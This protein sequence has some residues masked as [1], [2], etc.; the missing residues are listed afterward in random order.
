MRIYT[1]YY[2]KMEDVG[3]AYLLIQVSNTKPK[4]FPWGVWVLPEVYPDW[5]YVKGL[6][7]GSISESEFESAYREKLSRLNRDSILRIIKE[8]VDFTG[9]EDVMLLC[10]E[11][12]GDFCH[13]TILAEWLGNDI[14][15]F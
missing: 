2:K 4:W 9:N 8:I 11:K 6:K 3:P 15:E 14:T 10:W 13:R 5:E 12:S 7:D 1:S